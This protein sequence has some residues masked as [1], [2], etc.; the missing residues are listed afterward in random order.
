VAFARYDI[1]VEIRFLPGSPFLQASFYGLA[2]LIVIAAS[3]LVRSAAAASG[4]AP[5]DAARLQRRFL[6]GALVWVAV[7]SVAAL[8][9]LLLPRDDRPPLPFGL[10]LVSI[11]ALGIAVARSRIGDRLARGAPLA[12][13]VLFQSFRLPLELAMHRAYTEGLMP[14]Q[15]SYSGRNFDIVTG[16]TALVL[17]L[18]MLVI[19]VPRWIVM[20][21]NGLGLILLA[22]ILAVAMLSTP[23]FAYFGP[24]RLNVW[25]MWMPYTLLPAVMVLA[26]WAGQ[27]IVFRA[28]A[29][30]SRSIQAG[31]SM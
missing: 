30:P 3:R 21:W 12:W 26:A 24:D 23:I 29:Q 25:V 22:N 28:L 8:S 1:T 10:M 18:A 2:V 27:L 31:S 20:A 11:L 17:G 6:I 14:V 13:L 7:V 4:D 9:G 19:P 16:A 5:K 15:M